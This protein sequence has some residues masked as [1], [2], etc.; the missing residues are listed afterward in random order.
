MI[1]ENKIY[2]DNSATTQ[3]DPRVLETMLPFFK[4]CFGNASSLYSYG[5][6]AKET[7][8]HLR[9]KMAGFINA[10]TDEIIFT[11]GGTEANNLVLKGIAFA[12]REKGN[13]IIVSAIEHDCILNTCKWLETQGF[14]I[15]Y[16]PVD[17]SGV[18]DFEKLTRFIN[19]KTILVSIMH[20]NNEIGTIQNLAKIGSLCR[21]RNVPF[22]T[23]ACQSFGKVPIDVVSQ[24]VSLMTLNAHKIYGPK[25]VGCLYVKKGVQLTPLFH[26]GGQEFGIRSTTENIAGIAGFVKAAEICIHEIDI[27]PNRL[28]NLRNKL[29]R[30]LQRRFE[31]FYINGPATNRLPGNVNFAISGLE[32]ETIKILLMLDEKGIAVSAGSACSNNDTTKSAS[33]VLQAIGK[34]PFE[35]R[36]AIR[37]GIGRFNTESDIDRFIETFAGIIKQLNP[38]FS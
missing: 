17:N 31:G 35:A 3:L 37:I 25:G 36:G 30:E 1:A 19:P 38:I 15:T 26:G 5:T 16:L 13:H 20:A 33:H 29:I 10:Q 4:D 6:Q 2:L 24:H 8:E 28:F 32:G 21:E 27:E 14:Y 12:N 23:D 7:L 22:H 34:D 9:S 11:S 18:I